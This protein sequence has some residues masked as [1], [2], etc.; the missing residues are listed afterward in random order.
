[1]KENDGSENQTNPGDDLSLTSTQAQKG[2]KKGKRGTPKQKRET[3]YKKSFLRSW[4]ATSA[5]TKLGIIFAG[6]VAAATVGYLL[7]AAWQA[8]TTRPLPLVINYRPPKLLQPFVCDPKQG[9]YTGN[10]EL[11]AKNVGNARAVRANPMLM[12]MQIIPDKK[13]GDPF[14]DNLRPVN[15]AGK[16]QP[17]QSDV[18]FA[19]GQELF[20]EMRQGMHPFIPSLPEGA[21]VQFYLQNCIHYSDDYGGSHE[22]C[23]TFRLMLPSKNPLDALGGSPDFACDAAIPMNGEIHAHHNRP[24]PTIDT[25]RILPCHGIILANP[26]S[27]LQSRLKSFRMRTYENE[28][29]GVGCNRTDSPPQSC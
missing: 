21:I 20:P 3:E 2:K 19:V 13:T 9:L 23:D 6:I 5:V 16:V 15:C 28:G 1:M 18:N 12:R 22:T 29:W 7:V 25:D 17:S 24:L 8:W 26:V 27:G 4:R 14:F 10:M 11:D